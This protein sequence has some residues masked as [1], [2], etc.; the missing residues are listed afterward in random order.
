MTSYNYARTLLR[1]SAVNAAVKGNFISVQET[2][3]IVSKKSYIEIYSFN[4]KKLLFQI[5]F[6][7]YSNVETMH[8]YQPNTQS[9][10]SILILTD[11]QEFLALR[12]HANTKSI[13]TE[14]KL[15]LRQEN[16]PLS[17]SEVKAAIDPDQR[18]IIFNIYV[19]LLHVVPL[20]SVSQ[21]QNPSF[22]PVASL[23]KELIKPFAIRITEFNILS[24][25][26]LY[27]V[28]RPTVAVLYK[29]E[30]K[31][32]HVSGYE[33]NHYQQL[34]YLNPNM[35]MTVDISDHT[36][37]A[38]QNQGICVVGRR[39][40]AYYDFK[41]H[42]QILNI[43]RMLLSSY[44]ALNSNYLLSDAEGWL[45]LLKM[46]DSDL[47]SSM[48]LERI[49]QVSVARALVTLGNDCIYVGSSSGD[50]LLLEF[51]PTTNTGFALKVIQTFPNQGP[52][53]DFCIFDPDAQALQTMVCCSGASNT[54]SLRIVQNCVTF[55]E[56]QFLTI[57]GAI[58]LWSFSLNAGSNGCILI[59]AS[60]K[61]TYIF[62]QFPHMRQFE[63]VDHFSAFNMEDS[64][65]AVDMVANGGLVQVTA[66]GIRLMSATRDGILHAEWR[67]LPDQQR[68]VAAALNQSGSAIVTSTNTL[69]YFTFS[70]QGFI[71]Q[72]SIH[73]DTEV[74]CVALQSPMDDAFGL[75]DLAVVGCWT[76]K[77]NLRV[78]NSSNFEL[79]TSITLPSPAVPQNVLITSFGMTCCI[80]V[81]LADGRLLYYTIQRNSS[82]T[83]QN[84]GSIGIGSTTVKL[85]ILSKN[86][87]KYVVAYC[88]TGRPVI[89]RCVKE[90]IVCSAMALQN[91]T[92][93]GMLYSDKINGPAVMIAD[94]S[95]IRIGILDLARQLQSFSIPLC[96]GVPQRIVY[97]HES[98]TLAIATV[99]NRGS[100]EISHAMAGSLCI[101]D[102]KTFR[103]IE[104]HCLL[105]QESI[106]CLTTV[107]FNGVESVWVVAGTTLTSTGDSS[108]NKG[109]IL[110][111]QVSEKQQYKAVET[112]TMDRAV[113]SIQSFNGSLLASIGGTLHM[114]VC[115]RSK[116]SS[117]KMFELIPI[118]SLKTCVT[119]MDVDHNKVLVGD[120]LRS[121]S[122][123][124]TKGA[125]EREIS[126]VCSNHESH[127]LS[128]VKVI[129]TDQYMAADMYG[130]IRILQSQNIVA[131]KPRTTL[132]I[133]SLWH[134]GDLINGFRQGS[135]IGPF[136]ED[137]E[138]T[139]S[140]NC[141]IYATVT[142]SIGV[143]M[144]IP[145]SQYDT[146]H[147]LTQNMLRVLPPHELY[148]YTS[149]REFNNGNLRLPSHG[150]IDGDLI[151]RIQTLKPAELQKLIST[152][153]G[154]YRVPH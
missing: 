8:T 67:P 68:I 15:S 42:S 100:A 98:K 54:G 81:G 46:S 27:D 40:I 119:F 127:W 138:P 154:R 123:L 59:L 139:A 129:G 3:L 22:F 102:A 110:F 78:Y 92:A 74:A 106:S 48:K 23:S 80:F 105:D 45:Y 62:H 31:Q 99:G 101:I 56:L 44:G 51:V 49:A 144:R 38:V 33:I 11:Q 85:N 117:E 28:A 136:D 24:I 32:C 16:A 151:S 55:H 13:I 58:S 71:Q 19:N 47:T 149:L 141:F 17:E 113:C 7:L 70:E 109:R 79:M 87:A 134:F 95:T 131:E 82:I 103:D 41:G 132:D 2:N 26:M 133:V 96:S 29:D 146:L 121:M 83:L 5:D 64:T 150:F 93:F 60:V 145:Q 37:M 148:D 10:C 35:Q 91:V 108:H 73:L 140:T 126:V 65:L 115:T 39:S 20:T 6:S 97:H 12:Y 128:A 84:R 77:D 86:G 153:N 124:E 36:I 21:Q 53:N 14:I 116:A 118:S 104:T 94:Q 89:F 90:R 143:I 76:T 107:R 137:Y 43:S 114:I 63:Q 120:A 9:T 152:A 130:N 72:S 135:F 122:V 125:T 50:S 142:G 147:I 34:A 30:H 57:P 25:A 75:S 88:N 112:M 111:Y 1:S 52:I 18:L 4:E 61:K 66:A 69:I